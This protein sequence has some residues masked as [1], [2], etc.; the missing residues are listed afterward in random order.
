MHHGQL[1]PTINL[2]QPD[3][4]CDLDYTPDSGRKAAIEYAICNCIAFGSKNS[5][6]VL[7]NLATGTRTL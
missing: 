3:P 7:R 5:A 1:P 2:E 6:L 4:E